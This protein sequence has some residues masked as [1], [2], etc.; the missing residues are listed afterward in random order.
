[1]SNLGLLRAS[2]L[3]GV[4]VVFAA[5]AGTAPA[6]AAPAASDTSRPAVDRHSWAVK[7]SAMRTATVTR[8]VK[9]VHKVDPLVA[10]AIRLTNVERARAGCGAV[11]MDT[12]LNTAARLHSEDMARYSYFSHTSRDGRSPWD[13]IGAQGYTAGSGENIA[14]GYT[15]AA[16]VIKGWMDSPGHK[17]NMLNCSHKAVGIGIGR[18]GYYGLYW[19]QNFGRS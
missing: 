16:A 19:T 3:L 15:T 6:A 1:M 5:I 8:T 7:T 13:R 17:A 4:S 14:A 2:S 11:R 10:E 18:G 9:R 12:R